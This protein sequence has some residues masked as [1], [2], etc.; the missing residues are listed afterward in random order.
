[1]ANRKA[2]DKPG[3]GNIGWA[4]GWL[5]RLEAVT[6]RSART[7]QVAGVAVL[8]VDTSGSM[9][10]ERMGEAK[11]GA[12][13]FARDAY[14]SGYRLGLVTFASSAA[15]VAS[16]NTQSSDLDRLISA[17]EAGGG[18]NLAAGL[19]ESMKILE[20]WGPDRAICVVTDG[21]PDDEAS[22]LRMAD[23]AKSAGVRVLAVGVAGANE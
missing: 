2:L 10:G 1:M 23:M 6:G 19:T 13:G 15:T 11:S 12:L 9:E 4:S 20:G 3:R 17:L 22:A 14:A 7:P 5:D 18:T 16:P 21:T 8:L